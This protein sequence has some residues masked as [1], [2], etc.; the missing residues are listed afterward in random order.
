MGCKTNQFTDQCDDNHCYNSVPAAGT[1]GAVEFE[2]EE[3]PRAFIRDPQQTNNYNIPARDD[4]AVMY[5]SFRV[6]YDTSL[7][8]PPAI[9]GMVTKVDNCTTNYGRDNFNDSVLAFNYTPN[10][11]S[12]DFQYSDTWFSYLYDT[13]DKAGHIGQAAYYL[14]TRRGTTTTTPSGGTPSSTTDDGVRCIPCTNFTCSPAKTT[15]SYS[16]VEDLTG[17]SDCPHPTLF[18]IDTESLKVAFSYNQFSSQLPNGVLDFEVSFDGVTYADAWDAAEESGI[19]YTSSQN[20]WSN[21]GDGDAGFSDFEIFDIN[22]GANA[23]DL[24]I[25]FRI[26]SIFDDSGAVVVYNGTKWVAAE[27]L[28]PGTGF[29]VGQVFALSTP[30]RLADNSVVNLTLNLKI[31]SVG[32]V[33]VLS[34]GDPQ[35]IM[36][37]GDTLNGHRITRT[38]HTEVGEF[39]YHVAYLDGNGNDFVKDTQYTSSRNHIITAKAGYGIAD[40]AMMVGLYEFLDKSLQFV[41]GDVN[42]NAPDVFNTVRSPVAFISVNENGG[43]SDINIDSGVF[44]FNNESL[45]EL[46]TDSQ[47]SGYSSGDDIATSGGTGSGLTVNLNVSEIFDDGGSQIIDRI[48]NVTVHT[49]GSGY[50]VGDKITISGGSAKIQVLEVTNGGANLDKLDGPPI[51]EVNNPNDNETGLSNKST[52]DGNPEFVFKL[53]PSKLKFEM[54]TKDG[55]ADVEIISEN[56]GNNVPAIVKG[57]FTGGVL[58][59]VEIVKAGK[60]YSAATR[61]QLVIDNL[62]EEVTD[63]VKNEGYRD[64]LVDEFQGIL[65]DLPDGGLT[66]SPQD[67][68]A[69][70]DSYDQVPKTRDEK[71]KTPPMD[72][73]FDPDR[74]RLHQ[75]SQ[76]KLSKDTT[77]PLKKSI[78]PDYDLSYL[79][80]VPITSDYKKVIREDKKR[81]QNTVL[82]NIDDIT[83][84]RLPE[85]VSFQE[86][87]V[88]S[89][90]GS[91]SELPTAT[92]GTKYLMRQYRPDPAKVKKITVTL[93]CTPV[94]IGTSHFVC[95]APTEQTDTDT[96]VITDENGNTTQT[97]QVY[98]MGTVV[99]GPGCQTWS[100]SGT[101]TIWH[102]LSRD[103]RTVV[104]AAQA[105]GNPYAV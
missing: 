44:S 35:D 75:R 52:D 87:K 25:K 40:R 72:I 60:G 14:E 91:F 58:T 34:G 66:A 18:A 71:R 67:L 73:K 76:R 89:N 62:Y 79:K 85:V 10:E 42:E 39:P 83:Q 50:T 15:L 48:A 28:N 45:G 68:Q 27:I 56:G 103:A 82:Q 23:V 55:G 51:L 88:E 74:D 41:T 30:V 9:C 69:I 59:S 38:F 24:R 64:N 80:N 61:P 20:P 105:Y 36:R 70:S 11:L 31:T 104:R 54:V 96:G 29:S 46:N 93:G 26:E 12:F 57:D 95:N 63:T 8:A 7:G 2:Y 32:P 33:S 13:S 16:G 97:T 49:P 21:T 98:T 90:V 17:D 6:S 65:K 37:A 94:N 99:Q 101:M 81:S 22:D 5:E 84:E 3:Y 43:I 100:A 19:E 102:D 92:A 4:D 77:D 47:L 53:S 1:A 78:V 86:S